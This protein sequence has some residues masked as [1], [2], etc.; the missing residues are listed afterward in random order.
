M[1]TDHDVRQVSSIS[2]IHQERAQSSPEPIGPKGRVRRPLV[3]GCLL[4]MLVL[5][6]FL[7]AILPDL[8]RRLIE[9]A[10]AR[11]LAA[12][13]ELGRVSFGRRQ[14]R[15]HDLTVARPADLAALEHLH[16]AL[17]SAE[18]SLWAMLGG[19]FEHLAIAG[20]NGH[21]DALPDR[22]AMAR[23]AIEIDT[24]ELGQTLLTI[25]TDAT[26]SV[27]VSGDLVAV[28]QRAQGRLTLRAAQVPLAALGIS[29]AGRL[30]GSC[31][32]LM[33]QLVLDGG[34]EHF[35]LEARRAHLSV[36]AEE[37]A[38]TIEGLRLKL[39]PAV[40]RLDLDGHARRLELGLG[41]LPATTVPDPRLAATLTFRDDPQGVHLEARPVIAALG[42]ARVSADWLQG[43]SLPERFDLELSALRPQALWPDLGLDAV[44]ELELHL[45]VG[46]L[47]GE[48]VARA[49]RLQLDR[50]VLTAERDIVLRASGTSWVSDGWSG[51][52]LRLELTLPIGARLD[53]HDL[54]RDLLPL[55]MTLG[56][57]VLP[58]PLRFAGTA[59]LETSR[60]DFEALGQAPLAL[61]G[62]GADWHWHLRSAEL[63]HLLDLASQVG[64]D[65][66]RA[67]RLAGKVSAEGRL[68]GPWTRP[69]VTAALE[70]S[71]LN[72]EP[73]A[74]ELAASWRLFD[75]TGS[76]D[77]SWREAPDGPF[78]WPRL[79]LEGRFSLP[80]YDAV[81][82]K[83]NAAGH[84]AADLQTGS[85]ERGTLTVPELGELTLAGT[86]QLDGA[87]PRLTGHAELSRLPLAAALPWWF[88]AHDQTLPW[89]LEAR[90]AVE[91]E[92]DGELRI[93]GGWLADGA[94][95]LRDAGFTAAQGARVVEGLSGRW[96]LNASGAPEGPNLFAARG[97]TDGFLILWDTL[98]GD[99]SSTTARLDAQLGT[100]ADASREPPWT[101][102]AQVELPE[103]SRADLALAPVAEGD[104]LLLDL[105]LA[106]PDLTAVHQNYVRQLFPDRFDD[107]SVQG[108]LDGELHGLLEQGRP[109]Q[110]NGRLELDVERVAGKTAEVENLRLDLPFDLAL[111][112][113]TE[114]K[115]ATKQRW[116]GPSLEGRLSFDR[117][118]LGQRQLTAS[119]T[120]LAIVADGVALVEPLTSDFFGGTLTLESLGL[121]RLLSDHPVLES[122]LRWT[123]L[124]IDQLSELLGWVPLG[125]TLDGYLPRL[126]LTGG[127]LEVDGI[128]EVRLFGG[129]ATVSDISGSD[130]L[131]RYPKLTFSADIRD[132]DLEQL[133]RRFDFGVMTGILE[134]SLATCQL[135]RGVP[136]RCVAS[137]EAVRRKGQRQTIGVRAVENLTRLASGQQTDAFRGGFLRFFH[138]FP[139]AG[140]GLNAQ[141]DGDVLLLRGLEQRGDR[142]LFLRGR[143]PLRLDIVNARP[144]VAMSFQSLLNRLRNLD[145]AVVTTGRQSADD[146]LPD[147]QPRSQK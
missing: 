80:P 88:R 1:K 114:Q 136:T 14:L 147:S 62:R 92:L 134:G 37:I 19:R 107:A 26:T 120:T 31:E 98:F 24:L 127:E 8:P 125:G 84:S 83:L 121:A 34:V 22:L 143:W 53:G 100:H 105:E 68:L 46:Q 115:D 112:D 118:R 4:A 128:G 17:I 65:Q 61:D 39:E 126:R 67:L 104:D 79:D 132:I 12:H 135:F 91:A 131:G 89:D 20:A 5:G 145:L 73:A 113:V 97:E 57:S 138:T 45:A 9:A 124:Q 47:D 54:A 59:H 23:A 119:D 86:W 139:F 51:G 63:A 56:G 50:H 7:A 74:E 60:L 18:G 15:L 130:I 2:L 101:L 123:S 64:I 13:V 58:E 28:G 21:L 81:T 70:V 33:A 90:G 25:G 103:G 96:Q 75:A 71:E 144:G 32:D 66:T 140:F 146:K 44:L 49:R 133:T 48:L 93:G 94:L 116:E 3:I 137:L 129:S 111:K 27:V 77:L 106:L 82:L 110:L 87:T 69:V 40:G 78:E 35:E 72:V 42:E 117:F 52:P 102:S 41:Q 108:R 30:E 95:R 29:P 38:I 76:L 122:G 142:E 43:Q 99:F 85:L 11:Q 6:V 141:L 109:Q 16:V 55:R 36:P 10:L